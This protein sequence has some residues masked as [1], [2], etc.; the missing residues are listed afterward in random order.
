[1]N[2]KEY[3]IHPNDGSGDCFFIATSK[4]EEYKVRRR[5]EDI[6]RLDLSYLMNGE[7]IA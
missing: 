7:N 4:D 5:V 6:A 1:M 2:N 3:K